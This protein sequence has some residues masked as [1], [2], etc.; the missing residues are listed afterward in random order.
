M[1]IIRG[2]DN[3]TEPFTNAAMSIGNFDGVHIGHQKLLERL[4]EMSRR[5]GGPAVVMTFHPHVRRIFDADSAPLLICGIEERLE[6][7]SAAGV[8]ACIVVGSED[9]WMFAVEPVDYLRDVLID[10]LGCRGL[11]EGPTFHFG[12]RAAGTAETLRHEGTALGLEVEI[13]DGVRIDLPETGE[14]EINSTVVRDLIIAGHVAAAARCMGRPFSVT[15]VVV[16]GESRGSSLG[17]PTANL[18]ARGLLLPA[19]GVYAGRIQIDDAEHAA[20]VYVGASPTFA[21][22]H[23]CMEVHALDFSGDLYGRKLIVHL[24]NRLREDRK[25]DNRTSL[26][27]QI[28]RDINQIRRHLA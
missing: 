10:R 28:R 25:F 19:P 22:G 12:R 23:L 24:L 16:H 18:E 20:A 15:D 2:F 7:I 27:D 26:V 11:I 1:Q 5:L 8:D 14:V 9:R 3:L 6:R 21:D 17:F 13:I 4:V